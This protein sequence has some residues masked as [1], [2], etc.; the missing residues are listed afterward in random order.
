[1]ILIRLRV[2]IVRKTFRLRLRPDGEGMI[3]WQDGL[4]AGPF[5]C[6]LFTWQS[7]MFA[8]RF[9]IGWELT[10]WA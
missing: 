10:R 3:P 8:G 9:Q 1:M 6:F 4:E 7:Q 5:R 2:P